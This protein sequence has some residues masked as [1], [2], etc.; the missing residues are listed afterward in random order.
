MKY[1][2]SKIQYIILLTVTQLLMRFSQNWIFR[3][4]DYKMPYFNDG[5][6]R[7]SHSRLIWTRIPSWNDHIRSSIVTLKDS[8]AHFRN[9]ITNL[10]FVAFHN[11]PNQIRKKVA[12]IIHMKQWRQRFRYVHKFRSSLT[13]AVL[14]YNLFQLGKD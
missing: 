11:L 13:F 12:Q 7:K 3:S 2:K 5:S 6:T 14:N 8:E 9:G 10:A 4:F 1:V